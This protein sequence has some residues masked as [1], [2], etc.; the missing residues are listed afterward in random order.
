VFKNVEMC[1]FGKWKQKYQTSTAY[2]CL[3]FYLFFILHLP[4]SPPPSLSTPPPPQYV[5]TLLSINQ[6]LHAVP[7][8]FFLSSI[9]LSIMTFC[10]FRRSISSRSLE[11][12]TKGL[13]ITQIRY[14]SVHIQK[15]L[16]G[17]SYL[18]FSLIDFSIPIVKSV[19][20]IR[21]GFNANPDPAL[22]QCGSGSR[23][24][25]QCGPMRIRILVRL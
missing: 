4:S 6:P 9:L 2:I 19:L 20:W 25:N 8:F 3:M 11:R 7:F 16:S 13:N 17:T 10:S 24:P 23:E 15:A 22:P 12:Q 5:M 18:Y 14:P 1:W 21:I